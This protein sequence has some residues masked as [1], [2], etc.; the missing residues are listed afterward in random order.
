MTEDNSTPKETPFHGL[1][2]NPFNSIDAKLAILE[3]QL[4]QHADHEQHYPE[5]A[6][7]FD[8]LRNYVQTVRESI[9][10][11]ES[12]NKRKEDTSATDKKTKK[13]V[14]TIVTELSNWFKAMPDQ[15]PDFI[16]APN[17]KPS[18]M[19]PFIGEEKQDTLD[20]V[21]NGLRFLK[22]FILPNDPKEGVF[23]D[24]NA[25]WGLFHYLEALQYAIDFEAKHRRGGG[26][27]TGDYYEN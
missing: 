24:N 20:S 23:L 7:V 15:F 17:E 19:N 25:A 26:V 6:K 3:E 13:E 14:P 5:V 21:L 10:R 1:A 16:D 9:N 27:S 18:F 12:K 8:G 11:E 4:S 22:E 2:L